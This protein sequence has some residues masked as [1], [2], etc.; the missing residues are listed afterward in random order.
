MPPL[1]PLPLWIAL[2][3]IALF[4][5]VQNRPSEMERNISL[6]S[7]LCPFYAWILWIVDT[8][9]QSFGYQ[10]IESFHLVLFG[11]MVNFVMALALS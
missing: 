1:I 9:F 5:R 7:L 6:A 3:A 4:L 8:N 10:V 11:F 2:T